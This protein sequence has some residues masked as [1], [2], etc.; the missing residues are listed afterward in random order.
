MVWQSAGFFAAAAVF[1]APLFGAAAVF[2]VA[3]HTPLIVI[4]AALSDT[5]TT[6]AA[7]SGLAAAPAAGLA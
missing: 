2:G 4:T 7:A 1:P 5:S 6:G 3:A